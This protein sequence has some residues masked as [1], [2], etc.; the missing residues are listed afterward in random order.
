MS[1][2]PMKSPLV[3]QRANHLTS[4]PSGLDISTHAQNLELQNMDLQVCGSV[5]QQH[6]TGYNNI[7]A[8]QDFNPPPLLF[9]SKDDIHM[10]CVRAK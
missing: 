2:G 8:S 5:I 4:D 10:S 3:P 7:L 9:P 1:S 6:W